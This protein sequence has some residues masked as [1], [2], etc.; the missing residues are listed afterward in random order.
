[1]KMTYDR[2]ACAVYI[3]LIE[4]SQIARTETVHDEECLINLD[5]DV[6]GKIIGVE[7]VGL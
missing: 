6:E 3:Y 1:M 2:E 7:I 5:K 4:C